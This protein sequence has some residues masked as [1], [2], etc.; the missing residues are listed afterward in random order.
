MEYGC[1][2]EKLTHSFSK[3]IH[4]LLFDYDYEIK[5]IERE[6]EAAVSEIKN[7][8]ASLA[9]NIAEKVI[10]KDINESDY[11]RLVEEFI[12]GSGEAK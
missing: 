3:E 9:V 11:E 1:I 5:E 8:I 10:E 4:N 6:K 12:S 2:G 7:D